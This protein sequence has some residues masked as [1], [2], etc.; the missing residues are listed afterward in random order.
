MNQQDIDHLRRELATAKGGALN[1][2]GLAICWIYL[3]A[4]LDELESQQV[5]PDTT[6]ALNDLNKAIEYYST[7]KNK[8]IHIDSSTVIVM[9]VMLK[10]LRYELEN[11]KLPAKGELITN[12]D[13]LGS[14]Y[15][16]ALLREK[17]INSKL[18][19]ENNELKQRASFKQRKIERLQTLIKTCDKQLTKWQ[20]L[21]RSTTDSPDKDYESWAVNQVHKTLSQAIEGE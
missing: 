19:A 8:N 9:P 10:R 2:A 7:A 20:R 6:T 12:V 15:E 4:C 11:H 5:K 13:R 1:G 21:P 3:E 18:R 14:A 16:K 17:E